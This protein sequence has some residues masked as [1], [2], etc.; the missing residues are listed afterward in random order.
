MSSARR[1]ESMLQL[2]HSEAAGLEHLEYSASFRGGHHA[3]VSWFLGCA[4]CA[5]GLASGQDTWVP[6]GTYSEPFAPRLSTP[7]A[8]PGGPGHAV[9]TLDSPS[10]VV[11]ASNGTPDSAIGSAVHF[12]QPVW[13]ATR[14]CNS[15]GR[16]FWIRPC[17]SADQSISRSSLARE[18]GTSILAR[19]HF[20]AATAWLNSRAAVLGKKA[21][22]VFTNADVA[23]V[24]EP[25]A[26]SNR[27]K[28]DGKLEPRRD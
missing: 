15:I 3:S 1:L 18:H 25:T 23:R 9:L 12:N 4:L 21:S 22:R 24:N 13:Y 2:K 26:R 17:F 28:V 16:S 10:L 7:S 20:R 14:E 6:P 8:S 19:Q 27:G 5:C 11:G